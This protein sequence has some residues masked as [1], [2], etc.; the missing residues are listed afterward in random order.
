MKNLLC[1][2]TLLI[3]LPHLFAQKVSIPIFTENSTLLLE[4]DRDNRLRMVYFGKALIDPGEYA[5]VSANYRYFDSNAGIY[6]SVYTPAGSWNVSEP[7]I[8]V[9]HGDGN[10]SL[11][12]KYLS[13]ELE[14]KDENVTETRIVLADEIYPFQVTLFYKTWKRENV[15]EQW[16]EIEHNESEAVLLKKFA[17]SNLYFTNKEFYLTTF[18]NQWAKEM[19]PSTEKLSRGVRSVDSK[20]GTRAMLLETPHFILSFDQKASEIKEVLFSVI[21]HGLATLNSNLKWTPTIICGLLQG[22]IPTPL[23]ICFPRI[24][25]SEPLPLFMPYLMKV[26]EKP[27]GACTAGQENTGSWM[28]WA[29]V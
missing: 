24:R 14:Q 8:Q 7:A 20:L 22:L 3:L 25:P 15:I 18:H 11:D 17:S 4:T 2:L 13:H 29:V 5:Q 23:S 10:A 6:N 16:T 28:V 27:A 26:Q 9:I 1:S 21:W 12:L 19:Q